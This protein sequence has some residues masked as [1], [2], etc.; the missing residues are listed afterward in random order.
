MCTKYTKAVWQGGGLVSSLQTKIYCADQ[1]YSTKHCIWF[2][3][4][5]ILARS[6]GGQLTVWLTQHR[7]C[8]VKFDVKKGMPA[9]GMRACIHVFFSTKAGFSTRLQTGTNG[10]KC[11]LLSRLIRTEIRWIFCEFSW[12]SLGVYRSLNQGSLSYELTF[13]STGKRQ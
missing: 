5:Y 9:Y 10:G 11:A 2:R 1:Q 7:S 6:D 13:W 3:F 8:Y 4:A 12:Q